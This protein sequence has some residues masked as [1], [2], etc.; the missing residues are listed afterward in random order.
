MGGIQNG[1]ATSE[2]FPLL[3]RQTLAHNYFNLRSAGRWALLLGEKAHFILLPHLC[4]EKPAPHP[5]RSGGG[6]AALAELVALLACARGARSPDP[7][8]PLGLR[9]S[10]GSEPKF[11]L[12]N[13]PP[14]GSQERGAWAPFGLGAQ[15]AGRTRAAPP[16]RNLFPVLGCWEQRQATGAARWAP[17]FPAGACWPAPG[18][19]GPLVGHPVGRGRDPGKTAPTPVCEGGLGSWSPG[20]GCAAALDASGVARTRGLASSLTPLPLGP[21]GGEVYFILLFSSEGVKTAIRA[22]TWDRRL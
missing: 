10:E 16:K 22:G 18:G 4:H 13:G 11:G 17:V 20:R 9:W 15:N 1:C 14:L 21:A 2:F 3:P 7:P 5:R 12:S 19:A 6:F 8:A